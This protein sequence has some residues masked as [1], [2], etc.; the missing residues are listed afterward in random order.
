M[1]APLG[2]AAIFVG[3]FVVAFSGAV[4]PGP[5]TVAA[6]ERAAR[7]GV[8]GALF[9]ALG[10][11]LLEVLATAGL[12]LGLLRAG[13]PFVKG[14]IGVVGGAILLWMGLGMMRASGKAEIPQPGRGG[15]PGGPAAAA[16]AGVLTSLSNP[17][18]ALWWL[19]IGAKYVALALGA[20]IAGVAAF[21]IGHILGDIV[22]LS[23]LGVAMSRGRRLMS[24]RAYRGLILGCGLLLCGFGAFF[25]ASGLKAFLRP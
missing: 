2:V 5:V 19:T 20:G 13:G 14:A 10:H 15:N 21:Y 24:K 9:V 22:W 16:L 4:M 11:A 18:W 8:L 6:L 3:S 25:A 1:G 17:Y 7:V 23:A 12:A